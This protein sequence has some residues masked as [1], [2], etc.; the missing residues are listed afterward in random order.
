[1][2]RQPAYHTRLSADDTGYSCFETFMGQVAGDPFLS[3]DTFLK[4]HLVL[5][6]LFTNSISYASNSSVSI[7]LKIESAEVRVLYEDNGPPFNP[8]SKIADHFRENDI[9]SRPVGGL[10]CLLINAMTCN[11]S[12]HRRN[13]LNQLSFTVK[14]CELDLVTSHG[15]IHE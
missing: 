5:E 14:N 2:N 3:R 13:R 4:V 7:Q 11:Q 12:Y 9:D 15:V 1:M 8:L 6:E 10:G